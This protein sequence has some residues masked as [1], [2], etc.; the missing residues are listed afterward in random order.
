MSFWKVVLRT[1]QMQK[2]IRTS[3]EVRILF[4]STCIVLSITK[5]GDLPSRLQNVCNSGLIY[6]NP[7][8]ISSSKVRRSSDTLRWFFL[9]N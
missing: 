7:S 8:I 9:I 3:K 2:L 6:L 4:L 1:Q 5:P